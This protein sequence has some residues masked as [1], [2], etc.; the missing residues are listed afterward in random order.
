M[1]QIYEI[2]FTHASICHTFLSLCF[3]PVSHAGLQFVYG[4]VM[5]L[6]VVEHD[7]VVYSIAKLVHSVGGIEV[8][9][10]LL[11]GSTEAFIP[12]FVLA[13]ALAV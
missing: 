13:T 4:L 12:N 10:F 7:K 1:L 9:Q 6:A 11:Y 5:A 8:V 3:N 2:E